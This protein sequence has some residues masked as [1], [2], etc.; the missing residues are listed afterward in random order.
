MWFAKIY[1]NMVRNGFAPILG[2]FNEYGCKQ[3]DLGASSTSEGK[4]LRR[5]EVPYGEKPLKHLRDFY[6]SKGLELRK[7]EKKE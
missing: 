5:N 1:K 3:R 6:H 2:V 7:N 4:N